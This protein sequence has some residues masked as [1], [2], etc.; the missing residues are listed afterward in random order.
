MLSLRDRFEV[1]ALV[2]SCASRVVGSSYGGSMDGMKSAGLS[3]GAAGAGLIV[4]SF[5]PQAL[6]TSAWTVGGE[7]DAVALTK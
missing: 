4:T 6:G 3:V 5:I 7:G 1:A 2:G